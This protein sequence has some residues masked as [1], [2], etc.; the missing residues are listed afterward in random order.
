LVSDLTNDSIKVALGSAVDSH[1]DTL[2]HKILRVNRDMRDENEGAVLLLL[3]RFPDLI[4]SYNDE[5]LTPL[6]V[7]IKDFDYST[8]N[9]V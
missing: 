7:F 6:M 3:E 9:R 1:G 2:L 5:G 8:Y 4:N